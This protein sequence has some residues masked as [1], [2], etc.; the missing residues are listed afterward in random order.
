MTVRRLSIVR[1]TPVEEAVAG[2]RTGTPAHERPFL[3]RLRRYLVLPREISSFERAYLRRLNRIGLWFFV[4]HVPVMMLIAWINEM[5]T[6]F[7]GAVTLATVAGPVFAHRMLDNPRA[8]SACYGVATMI[9]G[10]VLVH[11]GQ[12]I[13]QIEM[14]FY[15]FALLAMLAVFGN[16]SV[17]IAAAATVTVHHIALWVLLPSSVF[18]YAAPMWVVGVHAAFV[19]LESVAAC[20]IA[21]SFFDNVI[22]LERIVQ[23]R[24]AA[25]DL[26]TRDMR[27]VLDN[28]VQGLVT[29]DRDAMPSNERSRILD[30]WFGSPRPGETIFDV[31]ERVSAEF[32]EASR[33]AWVEVIDGVMPLCLT[34]AQMPGILSFDGTHHRVTYQSIGDGEQPQ[35]FLV[36]VTDRTAD[37]ARENADRDRSEAMQ[38]FE[39]FAADRQAVYAFFEDASQLVEH[40]SDCGTLSRPVFERLVHTL[41]GNSSI[42]GLQSLVIEAHR[43]ETILVEEGR[44]PQ[45]FELAPLTDRWTSLASEVAR[46]IGAPR[47]LIEVAESDHSELEAAVRDG[48]ARSEILRRVH[49]LKLE[50]TRRRLE[51]FAAQARRIGEGLG[52][53]LHVIVESNDLRVDPK[54][55]GRFWNALIHAVRNAVDHGL[56]PPSVRAAS[57]KATQGTVVLRTRIRGDRFVVEVADDGRGVDWARVAAKAASLGLAASGAGAL[58]EALF[59]AGFSTADHV[60]ELSGRGLGLGA[61]KAA[62]ESLSG[63]IEV[64]TNPGSGTTI[65]MSF[66]RSMMAPDLVA[67]AS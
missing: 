7:I 26:R 23:R 55:W 65:R 44:M 57:G 17:I 60:S 37:V 30:T 16:P 38:L 50:P 24:T 20:F 36:V 34:L 66:A 22:G 61:L 33:V 58:E 56:E 32:A 13:V 11:T 53:E 59:R 62:T 5:G 2:E 9:M 49:A 14:H 39:R 29:I 31:F 21:R 63:T 46:L 41:K 52:K 28:V 4:A 6:A 8:V 1:G 47:P 3:A 43:L 27:R 25:L 45:Q 64:E 19:I 10:G 54:Y 67:L 42:F 48:E 15:F 18:N 51:H 35:R 12:G 40:I